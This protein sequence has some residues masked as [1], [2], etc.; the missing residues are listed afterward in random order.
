MEANQIR[1]VAT[2][3]YTYLDEIGQ[4]VNGYKIVF[5]MIPFAEQ[6]ILYA[7]SLNP[8]V[9]NPLM[10]KMLAERKLLAGQS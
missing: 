1:V 9:V 3:P 6:H 7:K 4:A 10:Q 2:Q 8:A 5:E